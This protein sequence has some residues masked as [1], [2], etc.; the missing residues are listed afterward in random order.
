MRW[1][2]L[3]WPKQRTDIRLWLLL[4]L[5]FALLFFLFKDA[6]TPR[7][8]HDLKVGSRSSE[9]VYAPKTILDQKA[10]DR[11]RQEAMDKVADIY[12]IDDHVTSIQ[13]AN[14]DR[15]F[16]NIRQIIERTDLTRDEKIDQLK[17][18]IPYQLADKAYATLAG[19]PVETLNSMQYLTK[20]IVEQ[21]MRDGVREKDLE[22]ARMR[23]NE[24]L[25]VAEL[26]SNN[27][28]VIQELARHSIV[29]NVK[30]D[31]EK[32]DEAKKAAADAV[33]PVYIYEGDI[34]LDY[35]QVINAEV[36]RKLELVGL[37]QTDKLKPYLG[38]A[39]L[40]LFFTLFLGV[41]M[42]RSRTFRRGQAFR[43]MLLYLLLLTLG[44]IYI[45]LFARFVPLNAEHALYV[46]PFAFVPLVIAILLGERVAYVA[47]LVLAFFAGLTFHEALGTLIDYRSFLY[48]ATSGMSGVFTIS[49]AMSR[50]RI[51]RAGFWV[52]LVNMVTIAMLLL[53]IG[54]VPDVRSAIELALFAVLS[55]MLAAVLTLGLLPFFEAAFGILSPMKLLELS[56]PNQPLLRKLLLEAPGTYHHSVMVANLAEAAAD[57]VGA[58]ALITRVGSYY[59]DI[60][61][62]KRP[63]YF[64]E[65][66]MGGVNPHD[67]LTPQMSKQIIIDHVI[68]G[69]KMLKEKNMPRAII[70]IAEQHHGTTLIKYFYHKAKEEAAKKG[71][72]LPKEADY[73]YPGPIPQSKE[74][75][76]VMIAD[77]VEATLRSMTKPT[78]DDVTTLVDETIRDKIEDGQF[79][80]VDLT[81]RDFQLIRE[82]ILQTLAGTF[83]SRIEYPKEGIK[84]GLKT[85]EEQQ[86][87]A[88]PSEILHDPAPSTSKERA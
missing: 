8:F 87:A 41:Y 19:T 72:P 20:Y 4:I 81:M 18:A 25:I 60:G 61:K 85:T 49:G 21:I 42:S 11:A 29:P 15:I 52:S 53:L 24:Q 50:S 51:L 45:Q 44:A 30:L 37:M 32:T 26:S 82:A 73:R 2:Q 40:M 23:V 80:D 22:A 71:A 54:T 43:P 5:F 38:M 77:T 64:V 10:T 75:A 1:A 68:D 47:S 62:T 76:I 28:L 7:S 17:K 88:E 14:L 74:A 27:R 13:L 58:D 39:L 70:E 16:D 9:R 78:M 33:E 34:L 83:H 84:E 35:N 63:R 31:R 79:A 56:S 12:K 66:Q 59:H 3:S 86:L 48:A 36:L 6:A 57:A 67:Q 69:V 46:T 55:G 65:N